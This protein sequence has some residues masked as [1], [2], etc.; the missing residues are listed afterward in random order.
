MIYLR[1]LAHIVLNLRNDLSSLGRQN[2]MSGRL[3]EVKRLF[4]L[5]NM[6]KTEI[7]SESLS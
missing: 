4:I 1:L 6:Q 2:D 3:S 7:L 5:V